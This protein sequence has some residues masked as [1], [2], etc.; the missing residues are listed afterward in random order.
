M[1]PDNEFVTL[2]IVQSLLEVQ[3]NAFKASFRV[4][5]DEL[6]DELKCVKK[7]ILDLQQSLSF[8]QGQLNSSMKRLDHVEKKLQD[9]DKFFRDTSDSLDAMD[10]ELEYLENQS[11]RNNIRITGVPEDTQNEK[12]WDDTE[13]IVKQLI[14]EKLGIQ[15]ELVIERC[16]RVKRSN[17]GYRPKQNGK[18]QPRNIVAKFASWKAKENVLRKARSIRP[19]GI[20]FVADLSPK[21]MAKREAQVDDLLEARRNGKYAFFVMDKLI[22]KEK[23]PDPIHEKKTTSS[24]SS[25][26]EVSFD[27]A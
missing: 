4:L 8:S 6:K 16:H 26:N 1:M 7:D 13:N 9:N 20:K 24:A 23:P 19:K 21:T 2:N 25:D 14:K 17:K 11:R 18:E 22:I 3:A 10:S 27:I 12:S 15:E 5:F